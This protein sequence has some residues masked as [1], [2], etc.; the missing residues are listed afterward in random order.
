MVLLYFGKIFAM[1]LVKFYD[2]H[3]IPS[4]HLT[5]SVIVAR[6][7]GK[8]VFVRHNDRTTWEV[9][10]GHIEEGESPDQAAARELNEE[11]GATQFDLSCVATYSVEKNGSTGYGRLFFA[12]VT[13]IVPISDTSEIAEAI[14]E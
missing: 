2:V 7:V 11:T 10:G 1:T 5:Y 9:P 12:E 13:A 8:W 4:G 6:H 3:Y 14:F